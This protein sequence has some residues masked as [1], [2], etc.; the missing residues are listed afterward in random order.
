M[1][2]VSSSFSVGPLQADGRNF[3]LE[4]HTDSTGG[5]WTYEYLYPQN[6]PY[7]T[8]LADRAADLA[9]WLADQ[10]ALALSGA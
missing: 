3:V 6:G 8:I 9:A 10:E 2:I 7:S 4:T 1:A 5:V